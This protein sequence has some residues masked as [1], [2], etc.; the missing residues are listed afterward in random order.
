MSHTAAVFTG[1]L[2]SLGSLELKFGKIMYHAV[3][4]SW[5]EVM[6]A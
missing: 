4:T 3:W 2:F 5:N 6:M 1:A